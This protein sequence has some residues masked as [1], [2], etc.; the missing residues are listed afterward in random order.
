MR[1]A[2]AVPPLMVLAD[3]GDGIVPEAARRQRGDAVRR[4]RVHLLLP[5]ALH[6]VARLVDERLLELDVADV[7][8]RGRRRER[9]ELR[10]GQAR[11]ASEQDRRL[12]RLDRMD[13]MAGGE[14][15]EARDIGDVSL[16]RKQAVNEPREALLQLDEFL[17]ADR[18][19]RGLEEHHDGVQRLHGVSL[20]VRIEDGCA[21]TLVH[22]C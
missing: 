21:M 18:A 7:H 20:C 4:M 22:A 2:R 9:D 17:G 13:V 8:E 5:L 11:G 14:R 1:V 19:Q 3:R 16:D 10:A 15:R 6:E 12:R